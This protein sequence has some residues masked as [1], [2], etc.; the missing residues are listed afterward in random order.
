M[1]LLMVEK[2]LVRTGTYSYIL[3]LKKKMVGEV[4]GKA[5]CLTVVYVILIYK[6]SFFFGIFSVVFFHLKIQQNLLHL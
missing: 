3:L 1:Y 2:M 4:H 6:L 5:V